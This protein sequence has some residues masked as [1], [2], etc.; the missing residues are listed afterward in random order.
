MDG[1]WV[2]WIPVLEASVSSVVNGMDTGTDHLGLNF[3]SAT[4]WQV[5][6]PHLTSSPHL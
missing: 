2:I 1:W 5:I 6:S 4:Y 3:G